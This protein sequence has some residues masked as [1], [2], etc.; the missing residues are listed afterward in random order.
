M[1]DRFVLQRL[2]VLEFK[3]LSWI[4]IISQLDIWLLNIKR[5][6]DLYCFILK[7]KLYRGIETH[8]Q[9]GLKLSGSQEFIGTY[10]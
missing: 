10:M 9:A 1:S 7:Y 5:K 4:I 2:L 6:I 8:R 3:L